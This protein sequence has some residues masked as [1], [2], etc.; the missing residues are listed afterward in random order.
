MENSVQLNVFR[1]LTSMF[2]KHEKNE[3]N[4]TNIA[5]EIKPGVLCQSVLRDGPMAS[6]LKGSYVPVFL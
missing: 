1:S 4:F 5:K 3:I 6:S 2:S